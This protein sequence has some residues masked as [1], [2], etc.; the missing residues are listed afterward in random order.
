M[1]SD[2]GNEIMNISGSLNV[3][4]SLTTNQLIVNE[5]LNVDNVITYEKHEVF[6]TIVL[7]IEDET[8]RE[9]INL[10]NYNHG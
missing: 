8:L 7:R 2:F 4:T 5:S 1:V 3:E 10:T 9:T 6:N